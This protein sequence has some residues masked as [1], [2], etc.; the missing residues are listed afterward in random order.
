MHI[1]ILTLFKLWHPTR[2]TSLAHH[3]QH[4]LQYYRYTYITLVTHHSCIPCSQH[5]LTCILWMITT[6]IRMMSDITFVSTTLLSCT[7]VT[8]TM[9]CFNTTTLY[10]SYIIHTTRSRCHCVYTPFVRY[11]IPH[12]RYIHNYRLLQLYLICNIAS[13]YDKHNYNITQ[14]N[15]KYTLITRCNIGCTAT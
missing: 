2:D 11:Y 10:I 8:H 4:T 12:I 15:T 5:I 14:H 13:R 6:L 1:T 3:V 9:P 7:L